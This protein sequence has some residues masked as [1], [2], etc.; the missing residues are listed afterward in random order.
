VHKQSLKV[1]FVLG[2]SLACVGVDVHEG[3]EETRGVGTTRE[4]KVS[5][6]R[7]EHD[8]SER[9]GGDEGDHAA[10]G[11]GRTSQ[12]SSP[13]ISTVSFVVVTCCEQ[14]RAN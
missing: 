10:W 2:R 14:H 7:G 1:A 3:I 11:G 6:T 9:E 4:C 8:R 12:P 5:T 13:S